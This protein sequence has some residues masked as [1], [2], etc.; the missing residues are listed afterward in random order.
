MGTEAVRN[1]DR[2][3]LELPIILMG[4]D[5]K[6]QKFVEETR[7]LVV[8]RNGAKII[9]RHILVPDQ[10]L[11]IRCVK[12]GRESEL[13]VAGPIG[14]D[15]ED[16]HYGVEILEAGPDFWGIDFPLLS[17]AERAASRLLLE[18][19]HCH[20]QEVAYLDVFELEVLL[21]NECL[22]RPCKRCA[23]TSMWIAPGPAGEQSV[24]NEKV[25]NPRHS[26][27]E[28][29]DPRVSLMVDACIRHPVYG[30]E[31]VH[32]ENVSRGGFRFRSS[33]DYPIATLLE[34]ALPYVPGAANIFAP[35]RIVYRED[36][37]TQAKRAYGV[38]YVPTQM[39]SSLTGMKIS[40]PE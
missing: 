32:T 40:T 17:V 29:K 3:Y 19:M 4:T 6:G 38:A 37:P 13:R 20:W 21:A 34:V 18:C 14:G 27:Q 15:G 10:K 12:T 35:V 2:V 16:Y 11:R 39:A 25:L 26:I 5:R 36:P 7:T 28:R 24:K 8:A 9:S 31:V 22:A 30:D 33:R 23:V 1:S